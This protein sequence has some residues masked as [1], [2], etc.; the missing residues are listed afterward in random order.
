MHWQQAVPLSHGLSPS[1]GDPGD[2][3]GGGP[4][5]AV[6]VLGPGRPRARRR[7]S[8][9]RAASTGRRHG[10]TFRPC[11]ARGSRALPITN[12]S[13]SVMI[14]AGATRTPSPTAARPG[15]V[16]VKSEPGPDSVSSWPHS[17]CQWHDHGRPLPPCTESPR[18]GPAEGLG[19]TR[20]LSHRH[21]AR[22]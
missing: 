11:P 3:A 16:L 17:G 22:Q 20:S 15:G 6:T 1:H 14:P 10:V 12:D 2:A 4:A 18:P 8:L 21:G 19:L 13:D 9:S 5:A 7:A